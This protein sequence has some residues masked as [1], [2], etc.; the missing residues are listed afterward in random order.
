MCDCNAA[1]DHPGAS[2]SAPH[3]TRLEGTTGDEVTKAACNQTTNRRPSLRVAQ[4]N[5]KFA[6]PYQLVC[7]KF[8]C[9]VLSISYGNSLNET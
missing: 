3:T 1:L 6:N 9:R 8:H 5:S 4:R 2:A 7:S